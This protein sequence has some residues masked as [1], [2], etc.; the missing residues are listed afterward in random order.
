MLSMAWYSSSDFLKGGV[1][2]EIKTS[3]ALPERIDL[4]ADLRPRVTLPDFMTRASFELIVSDVDFLE[5]LGATTGAR[6]E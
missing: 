2:A 5:A 1:F 6:A 4:R 3:L